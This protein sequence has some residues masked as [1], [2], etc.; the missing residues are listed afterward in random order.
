MRVGLIQ[1]PSPF[2]IDQGVHPPL[3]LWCLGAALK[4]AGHEVVYADLGLGDS[5]PE[6]CDVWGLT[7]TT[8]QWLNM[9][10]IL[11]QAG[12]T[13]VV[14]GGPHATLAPN[15]GLDMGAMTVLQGEG[16]IEFPRLLKEPLPRATVVNAE[17]ILDL[18]ALPFPDRSQ[19]RRYH[20]EIVDAK[21]VP[22]E[23]TTAITSRGCPHACAFCSHAV[24]N[25]RYTTRS[26]GN[27]VA[28]AYELREH[29]GYD[30]VHYFDDC[31]AISPRRTLGICDGL[32]SLGMTWRAFVRADQ[33]KAG[34]LEA[35]AVSGC[36]EIGIG[37]ESGSP[38]ILETIQKGETVGQQSAAIA[39]A[40]HAG[41]R[42]KT[43]LIVGLPGETWQT[44]DETAAFL[45]E[46]QPDD[47]DVTILQV[48]PGSAIYDDPEGYGISLDGGPTWYK[49][50][51]GEY[52]A[53][54]H[55]EMLSPDDLIVARNYLELRFKT[56]I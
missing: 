8:P 34:L 1:P 39:M 10:Y 30:A 12:D 29:W 32:R 22:H 35:M 28:E 18:D 40:K 51:P 45:E 19:A 38:Q 48:Y 46:T 44:I 23:A 16:E 7:G 43:F 15:V 9:V 14:L 21:G 2:L 50:L 42:V 5:L 54:H 56:S 25:R 11:G 49:G 55:T 26:I 33:C 47:V 24:W 4:E 3:G 31:F 17:R 41:L 37:V 20:Y 6:E 27:V 52:T 53:R 13:P 36:A